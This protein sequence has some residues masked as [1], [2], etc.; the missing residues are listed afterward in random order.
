MLLPACKFVAFTGPLN[1]ICVESPTAGLY[2]ARSTD[3]ALSMP[4]SVMYRVLYPRYKFAINLC[5]I[6]KFNTIL[7]SSSEIW[8]F[9]KKLILSSPAGISSSSALKYF[10]NL[11][12][13]KLKVKSLGSGIPLASNSFFIY[14]KS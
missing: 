11:A 10:S 7:N 14:A 12:D 3:I 6:A 13:S 4:S 5:V 9:D 1:V 2:V 8:C